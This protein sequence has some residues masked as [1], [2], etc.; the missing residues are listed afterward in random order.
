MVKEIADQTA[1]KNWIDKNDKARF[2]E[3]A[4]KIDRAGA[5]THQRPSWRMNS[6]DAV[7]RLTMLPLYVS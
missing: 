7:K 5:Q 6:E 3:R 1:A 2:G 4:L